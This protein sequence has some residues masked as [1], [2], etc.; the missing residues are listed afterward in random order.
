[1]ELYLLAKSRKG[2]PEKIDLRASIAPWGWRELEITND[3]IAMAMRIDAADPAWKS[4][5]H[6]V[7]VILKPHYKVEGK[8]HMGRNASYQV[9]FSAL[10]LQSARLTSEHDG[11]IMPL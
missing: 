11:H 5:A 4:G 1:M 7:D 6:T 3:F 2:G 10:N 8:A 9:E